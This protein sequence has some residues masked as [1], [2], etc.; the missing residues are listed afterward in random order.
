MVKNK[1]RWGLRNENGNPVY[2][3]F[4]ATTKEL[5][6]MNKMDIN[7]MFGVFYIQMLRFDDGTEYNIDGSRKEINL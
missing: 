5:E 1:I 3:I 6:K 4:E 2:I 7:Y